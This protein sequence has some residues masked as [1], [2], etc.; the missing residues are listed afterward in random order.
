MKKSF[1]AILLCFSLMMALCAPNLARA[2]GDVPEEA[3]ATV[4]GPVT[5]TPPVAPVVTDS[6]GEA[7]TEAT[8]TPVVAG[9]ESQSEVT[10]EPPAESPVS[11]EPPPAESAPEPEA[12]SV[13]DA[14]EAIADAGA[15]LLDAEGQPIPLA[16][17]EAAAIL[18]APDPVACPPGVQPVAWGG[19]G[20]G[21]TVSYTSI[22]A[23]IDDASVTAGWTVYIDPGTFAE[24]VNVNK[25]VTLQGSGQ[26]AT[27]VVPGA[28]DLSLG[29]G[30]GSCP[31]ASN[32]VIYVTADNV[33]IR[34]LTVNGNNS[35]LTS[36]TLVD[37]EDIDIRSGIQGNG[38]DNFTVENVTVENV[39]LRGIQS[40]NGSF[41][42]TDNTV[43]NVQGNGGSIGMFNY[44]G[45]GTFDGNTVID[46][47]DGIASNWST[48]VQFTNNTVI[49]SG[50]GIHTDNSSGSDLIANNTI[51]DSDPG[52]Y[53]IWVFAPYSDI[54]VQDNTITNVDVG[55][56]VAGQNAPSTAVFTGNTVDGSDVAAVYVTTSQFGFG[57][58]D[59][60]AIF[61]DNTII[62]SGVG[63]YLESEDG[64]TLTVQGSGNCI[65]NN[66]QGATIATGA[67]YA[68]TVN[69]DL[70]GN[71]WGDVSGP[72][73]A[74]TN[75]TG[76]GNSVADGIAFDPFGTTDL[77]PPPPAEPEPEPA[78]GGN[79]L[80][81]VV[82]I[83]VTGGELVPVSCDQ[84]ANFTLRLEN[85]NEARFTCNVGEEAGLVEEFAE[86]L[87]DPLP[88]GDDFV[89]GL[90][91]IVLTNGES[92]LNLPSDAFITVSFVIPAEYAGR[93]LAILYWDETLNNGQ[94]DWVEIEDPLLKDGRLSAIVTFT[95]MFVL[96]AR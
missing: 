54:T 50:S 32:S 11:T 56:A 88:T 66:G 12:A 10:A 46:A 69:A 91:T 4:S 51:Q 96:T 57:S 6:G 28:V 33:T 63:F 52:G 81:L 65:A 25:S 45:S 34:D 74:T 36:G 68:G 39:F 2:E 75:S 89:W 83:P 30:F 59:V 21:C 16:S 31:S 53:G 90:T 40:S 23:A 24:N 22:Q 94:G 48:G 92:V 27:I 42:F 78:S 9:T 70:T 15:V 7:A 26:G 77:C 5:E 37:G 60:S 93:S 18:T 44:V 61:T 19:T 41:T 86:T 43:T 1:V 17:A 3:P 64:N 71:W 80:P 67:G 49:S 85:E 73:N 13:A 95:G 35:A 76:A 84:A 20:I 58:N 82:S 55:L 62:N 79:G 29:C 14:V 72:F 87:P 8:E 47:N 38:A